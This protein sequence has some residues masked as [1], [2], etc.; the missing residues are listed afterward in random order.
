MAGY[1]TA[2]SDFV[3]ATLINNQAQ[4]QR[5]EFGSKFSSDQAH[6]EA[7]FTHG[8]NPQGKNA[9]TAMNEIIKNFKEADYKI[10]GDNPDFPNGVFTDYRDGFKNP[11]MKELKDKPN[12]FGPNIALPS[13]DVFDPATE[14]SDT[15][16]SIVPIKEDGAGFGY[17]IDRNDRP[18]TGEKAAETLGTYFKRFYDSTDATEISKPTLGE[19]APPNK[20]ANSAE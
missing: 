19:F 13:E 4:K 7:I 18:T 3:N 15:R 20:A 11:N 12:K 10:G 6:L 17:K 5:S 8:F 2:G 16:S 1:K 14:R 9:V